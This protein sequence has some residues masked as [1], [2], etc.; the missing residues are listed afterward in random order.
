MLVLLHNNCSCG[1]AEENLEVNAWVTSSNIHQLEQQKNPLLA[2]KV[3]HVRVKVVLGP[4]F[5]ECVHKCQALEKR[6]GGELG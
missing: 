6:V 5:V 4:K 1:L 2:F 3:K